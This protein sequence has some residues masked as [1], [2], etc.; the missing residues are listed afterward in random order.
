MMQQMQQAAMYQ[1]LAAQQMAGDMQYASA[2]C[3]QQQA[4]QPRQSIKGGSGACVLCM[5]AAGF[6]HACTQLPPAMAVVRVDL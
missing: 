6:L 1:Q 5:T 3:L 2:Y 4:A